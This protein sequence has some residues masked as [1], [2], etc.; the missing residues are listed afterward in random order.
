[1]HL[2]RPDVPASLAALVA[3]MMAKDPSLRFQEPEELARALEPFFKK[4]ASG[5]VQTPSPGAYPGRSAANRPLIP[6]PLPAMVPAPAVAAAIH[7]VDAADPKLSDRGRPPRGPAWAWPAAGIGALL[8]GALLWQ[9]IVRV[10]TPDGVI[11]IENLPKDAVVTVEGNRVS[12]AYD[13]SGK[14]AEV[15][16]LPGR[17]MLEVTRDDVKLVSEVVEFKA[18]GEQTCRVRIEPP[19]EIDG[20][21]KDSGGPGPAPGTTPAREVADRAPPTPERA[22]PRPQV[23]AMK[24]QWSIDGDTLVQTSLVSGGIVPAHI[25]LKDTDLSDYNFDLEAKV[26]GGDHGFKVILHWSGPRDFQTFGAGSYGNTGH[27]LSHV[28]N[29]AW[30]RDNRNFR[31]GSLVPGRWYPIRVEVRGSR[32]RCFLDG[33]SLF[34][35]DDARFTGGLIGLATWG[36]QAG[37]RRLKVTSPD[38][39]TLW[40]GL[41]D[42]PR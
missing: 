4:T 11:V 30:G 34:E 7:P 2:I 13:R 20:N 41:P 27:D 23:D 18:T 29:G 15:R 35:G 10:K 40:E 16:S 32:V 17:R 42:L 9:V 26:I 8:L 36:T 33:V 25:L 37:F 28:L 3:K 21:R 5:P 6:P 22:G 1:M 38:G 31:R 39:T 12:F 14:E 19:P 24:G